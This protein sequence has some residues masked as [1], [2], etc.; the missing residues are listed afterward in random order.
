M[1]LFL[2]AL[3]LLFT[4]SLAAQDLYDLSAVQDVY[5][6]F[7]QDDWEHTL[8]SFKRHTDKERLLAK[9]V[10][11]GKTYDSVGVRYKGNSSF[12]STSKSEEQK[13]PFNIKIDHIKK[14]QATPEGYETLKLSNVFRDPSFVREALSYEIAREYM[15]APRCNFVRLYIND[16]YWGLYNNSQSIDSKFLAA[17]FGK[18]KGAFFKCDPPDWDKTKSGNCPKG[19]KSSLEY[20]GENINCYRQFY[21]LKSDTVIA[22]KALIELTQAIAQ[23]D[24]SLYQLLN[25]DETLW[26]LAFNN[27]LVNLDSYTGRL[28]HNYYLYEDSSGQFHPIIWD[29]NMSFGGFRY[30]DS[31]GS[32]E[33][34]E[35]QELS[36][37]A[38]YTNA[39]SQ[40]PL[41][42]H[43]LR[44]ELN[45]KIYL[46][47]V[48]TIVEEQFSNHKYQ[49]RAE[50]LQQQLD[51]LVKS[52]Q[53]KLYSYE[54]FQRNMDSTVFI[55][56]YPIIGI[57]EL[58]EA[59]VAYLK[60]HPLLS[61]AAPTISEANAEIKDE[62]IHFSCTSDGT[63][64]WLFYRSATNGAFQRVAMEKQEDN[65]QT[66]VPEQGTLQYYFVA[67]NEKAAQL[68]PRRAAHEFLVVGEGSKED[69]RTGE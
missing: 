32:L 33:N 51:E 65:W 46:A 2:P 28:C 66:T 9:L 1:R 7:E 24:Q 45:R 36:P 52:D 34:E 14:K 11:R 21:E 30:L 29:L 5:L 57:T 18:S 23:H 35:L 41:I 38:H 26:M 37:L 62:Q 69:L 3:F 63:K 68:L 61:K 53:H 16:E 49:K 64:V 43:L 19:D 54:D 15:A 31:R 58:M 20:L 60:K 42:R 10:I 67:E 59:R 17:N 48:R 12:F 4:V 39:K 8:D 13:L 6:Y 50:A 55:G 44:D 40:R 27:V 47:H 22:W 25:V 56:K